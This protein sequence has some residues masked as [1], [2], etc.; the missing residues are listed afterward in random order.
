[1]RDM[2]SETNVKNIR[3]ELLKRHR[4]I[5]SHNFKNMRKKRAL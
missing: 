2:R 4:D 1:M 5:V 3:T